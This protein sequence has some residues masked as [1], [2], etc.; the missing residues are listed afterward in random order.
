MKAVQAVDAADLKAHARPKNIS[1]YRGVRVRRLKALAAT[2]DRSLTTAQV[3]EQHI[4]P[5]TAARRCRYVELLEPSDVG[6]AHLFSSH[7]WKA[8]FID[9]VA[10]IAHVATDDMCVWLD[11]FAVS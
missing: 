7:T 1:S 4:K 6:E 8:P 3:V 5:Q 9:L 2:L 11:I 10:A